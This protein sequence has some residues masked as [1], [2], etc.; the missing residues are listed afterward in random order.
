MRSKYFSRFFGAMA[1]ALLL[2]LTLV[3][4]I[5]QAANHIVPTGKTTQQASQLVFWYDQDQDDEDFQSFIQVTNASVD[6]PVWVH[7]QV[8]ASSNPSP[9]DPATAVFCQETNFNDFY[10]PQ[11]THIY[12]MD[13]VVTND[14]LNSFDVGDFSSP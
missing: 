7:V 14:P 4:I 13:D 6:T 2:G 3:P 12:D 1:V 11:D 5:S 10:T 9:G 8:F